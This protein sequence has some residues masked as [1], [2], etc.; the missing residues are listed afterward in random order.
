MEEARR[1]DDQKIEDDKSYNMKKMKII[2]ITNIEVK[3]QKVREEVSTNIINEAEKY[4]MKK[5][6]EFLKDKTE[7]KG[8]KITFEEK[9]AKIE[10]SMIEMRKTVGI[11]MKSKKMIDMVMKLMTSKNSTEAEKRTKELWLQEEC[12]KNLH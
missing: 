3:E 5:K 9:E 7:K 10:V 11:R 2:K 1:I 6:K 4:V 8:N 12:L